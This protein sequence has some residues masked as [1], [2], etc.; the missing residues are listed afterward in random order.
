MTNLTKSAEERPKSLMKRKKTSSKI[1]ELIA[2]AKTIENNLH[3]IT[4]YWTTNAL[5]NAETEGFNNIE[6]KNRII[7]LEKRIKR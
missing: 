6:S 4:S 7:L 5:S 1:K 3:G 2:M